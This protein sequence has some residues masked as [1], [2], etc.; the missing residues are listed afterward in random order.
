MRRGQQLQPVPG[1]AVDAAQQSEGPTVVFAN[2]SSNSACPWLA[3]A[4]TLTG[5]SHRT[6][7]FP[8]RN[9]TAA[10][11]TRRCETCSTSPTLAAGTAPTFWS[12]P[13]SA[14][15]WSSRPA[16]THPARLAGI[17]SLSGERTVGDYR[18]IRS[19]A[20]RVTTSSLDVG[21]SDDPLTDGSRQPGQ[22]QAVLHGHPRQ[23]LLLPG[24]V[25]GTDLLDA[26]RLSPT[27]LGSVAS[28]R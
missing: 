19:G 28:A 4:H 25:H 21:S 27:A 14:V 12:A 24:S 7:V 2:D 5:A 22:L 3:L 6:V 18:D 16:A 10:G 23:L 17:I 9:P 26:G 13:P 20:R 1:V 8:Y 15:D 11:E